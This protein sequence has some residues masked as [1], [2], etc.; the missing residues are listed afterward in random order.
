[1]SELVEKI[2]AL[3]G[4]SPDVLK[5]TVIELVERHMNGRPAVAGKPLEL[6]SRDELLAYIR[7][8]AEADHD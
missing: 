1:M 8:Y 3:N 4:D 6:Q 5:E 2:R 7:R